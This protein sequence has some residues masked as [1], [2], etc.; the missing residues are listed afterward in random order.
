MKLFLFFNYLA[1]DAVF[2]PLN[3][4]GSTQQIPSLAAISI[5]PLFLS[6]FTSMDI[7]FSVQYI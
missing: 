1:D 4:F 5:S 3:S 7:H 6:S 2:P